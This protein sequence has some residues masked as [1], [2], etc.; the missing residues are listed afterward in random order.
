MSIVA[1]SET[2]G[3][4]GT[5]IGRRV[6]AAR[7][8][9][10]ADR[11]I[12]AKAAERFHEG[13]GELTHVTEERP[14]LWERFTDTQR[15][16]MTYV[17]AILL[18]LA[19]RDNVVLVGRAATLLLRGVGHAMRVRVSAP[20]DVRAARL[21]HEQGL[22][23]EAALDLVHQTDRERAARVRFLYHVDWDDPLLYDLVLSTDRLGADRGARLVGEA[24][25]DASVQ[26]TPASRR[27]VADLAIAAQARAALLAHP[28]T[29]DRQLYV[30]CRHGCVTLSGAV[31]DGAARRAAAE[32]VS[33]IAGVSSLE[34][35]LVTL[36]ARRTLASR[37]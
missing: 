5:E 3:S 34:N 22:T 35:E 37:L 26:P 9:E 7:G 15:R 6:A 27:Q 25:D 10:L 19:A 16:Y 17:E 28:L 21:Q 33:A 32:T 29:R 14:T 12:I 24:L 23:P 18:E 30:S 2:L 1:I 8:F 31:R 20:E 36:D 4:L 13:I 11:E